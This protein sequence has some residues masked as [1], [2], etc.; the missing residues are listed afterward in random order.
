MNINFNQLKIVLRAAE[1][2]KRKV[3]L[4][5]HRTEVR[6]LF[7]S[8]AQAHTPFVTGMDEKQTTAGR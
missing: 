6:S 7:A 5:P 8:S 3:K 1:K 2:V 4:H